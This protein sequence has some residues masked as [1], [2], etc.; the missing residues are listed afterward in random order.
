MRRKHGVQDLQVK[1]PRRERSVLI[2]VSLREA[3]VEPGEYEAKIM[4]DPEVSPEI[5]E[6]EVG[7][8]NSDG[9]PIKHTYKRW[10]TK[11]NLSFVIDSD[12]PDGVVTIDVRLSGKSH[13]L[14]K[15]FCFW[16]VK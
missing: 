10:G 12:T 7:M 5:S 6:V 3:Y 2:P 14:N 15:R 16:H 11:L 13:K 4:I 1:K 8:W 9:S